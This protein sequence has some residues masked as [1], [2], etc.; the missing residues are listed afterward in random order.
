MRLQKLKI[1][2]GAS[3]VA[4]SLLGGATSPVFA[5]SADSTS[6]LMARQ[7]SRLNTIEDNL[8]TVRGTLETE[9][10]A[11]RM[12]IQD[13]VENQAEDDQ[14]ANAK[15]KELK[16]QI[17]ELGDTLDIFNQRLRR[18]IELS[19]DIEF[20]V[21]RMEKRMQTLLSLS[22][23]NLADA[24]LQEDVTAGG[25]APAV[26]M[27]RDNETGGATWTVEKDDDLS[28]ELAKL[29]E[30]DNASDENEVAATASST[31]TGDEGDLSALQDNETQITTG[32]E[33][34]GSV[35]TQ[36]EAQD[37]NQDNQ[38]AETEV[39]ST[40]EAVISVLPEGSPEEQYRF[41]FGRM[42]Q[43]DL[44]TAEAG[45]AE[46]RATHDS[47]ER[48]ADV[49]YWLGR[50]QF[51]QGD[52]GKSAM[53]FTEFNT[54]FPDDSRLPEAILMIA[55]SV[56]NFATAEQACQ[57]FADLP[58]MLDQPTEIFTTRLAELKDEASCE[59]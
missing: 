17:I 29:G 25:T 9:F 36:D 13:M 4:L 58:Q 42:L 45:F 14:L 22:G 52:Y 3:F 26:S 32:A 8:K 57:I 46:F 12:Q 27:S 19:S 51:I 56:L 31:A 33:A 20:R 38:Q 39:A 5:Q 16:S 41:A 59:G 11:I 48:S 2:S 37:L 18:S 10:R 40:Q 24:I 7:Q 30:A 35:V 34:D 15:L 53:S 55:E 21:L 1:I 23:D 49:L 28:Q 47:H 6:A 50:V 44:E 54:E 43:N